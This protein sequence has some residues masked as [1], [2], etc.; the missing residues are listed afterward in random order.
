MAEQSAGDGRSGGSGKLPLRELWQMPVLVIGAT[1]LLAGV[2]ANLLTPKKKPEP[3]DVSGA[4][5][6]AETLFMDEHPDDAVRVLDG[7]VG[8]VIAGGG[9]TPEERARFRLL[10]A[11]ARW[12]S[13]TRAGGLTDA[14]ARKVIE[15]YEAAAEQGESMSPVRNARLANALTVVGE[16][17]EALDIA[18]KMPESAADIRRATLR[19]IIDRAIEDSANFA[20]S[21]ASPAEVIELLSRLAVDPAASETERVWAL[22]RQAEIRLAAG[23]GDQAITHLLLALPR[24]SEEARWSPLGGELLYLLGRAYVETNRLEEGAKHLIHAQRLLRPTDDRQADVGVM[25]GRVAQAGADYDEARERYLGVITQFPDSSGS[26]DAMLGVAECEAAIGAWDRAIEA[27]GELA[28]ALADGKGSIGLPSRAL[29]S[30]RQRTVERLLESQNEAA[31]RLSTIGERIA[32]TSKHVGPDDDLWAIVAVGASHRAL[33]AALLAP[34]TSPSGE[35]DW[36][37]V[38]VA[39]R[40]QARAHFMEAAGRF[41][42]HARRVAGSDEDAYAE[43]L[44][45]AADAWDR[46]GSHE[47]AIKAFSEYANGRPSDARSAAAR[48]RVAQAHQ[49]I[50]EFAPAAEVYRTLITDNPQSGER[51]RSIVPLARTLLADGES[52]ND[53]EAERLLRLAVGGTVMPPDAPDFRI[54]LNELG[55]HY[56]RSGRYANAI[57]RLTESLERYPNGGP[58][59]GAL[60]VDAVRLKLADA[61]RLSAKEIAETLRGAMPQNERDEL[62]AMREKRLRDAHA[63]Y[64]EICAAAVLREE[65]RLSASERAAVRNAFFYRGDAAFDLAEYDA[66]IEAYDV[67]ANRYAGDPA[68]LVAMIQIVNAYAQTGRMEEARTANER[69]RQRFREL[70]PEAFDRPDLPIDR[71]HWERWL[72]SSADLASRVERASAPEEGT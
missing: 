37:R 57:E 68:S 19:G 3:F 41:A 29:E 61:L 35:V 10:R 52:G 66:A 53:E 55:S 4:L 26:A 36:S 15:D 30:V 43:S 17:A 45:N 21:S 69:A 65:K 28:A 7:P 50:G 44:W 2:A 60:G 33:G 62:T 59:D 56:L 12:V 31:L 16:R 38:D 58:T 22:A 70:P 42:A 51:V 63:M 47:L 39:T 25:L 5:V 18:E 71:A 48:L 54:A 13:G 72:E 24:L 9:G 8:R 27:F 23:E 40:G 34:A 20:H 49:A 64:E 67:A 46:A 14:D 32:T 1:L 6:R 11:D